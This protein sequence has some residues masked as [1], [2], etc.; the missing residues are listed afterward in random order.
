MSYQIDK[1]TGDIVMNGHE[2]GIADDPYSGIS[3]IRNMNLI[4]VPKEASVNFSTSKISYPTITNLSVLSSNA[5]ADTITFNASSTLEARMAIT[6]SATTIGGTSTGVIYYVGSV[7]GQTTCQLFTD[8]ALSALVDITGASGTATLSTL[9]PTKLLNWAYDNVNSYYY[10][11]D[12]SGYVWGTN[13]RTPSNFWTFTGNTTVTNA[14]G[15]GLVCYQASDG[16][17]GVGSVY[18][19]VFRNKRIDYAISSSPITWHYN[20][21]PASGAIDGSGGDSMITGAGT[22][23]SHQALVGQDNTVYYCDSN[24]LGSF[25]EKPLKAFNP[26]DTTTY[27]YAQKALQLPYFERAQCLAELGTNLLIGGIKSAIYPW[28]RISTSFKYPILLAENNIF[29]MVTVNTNTFVFIGNRG[30][31]Y[32]TNGTQGQ[33][34]KKV[35][36]H[37]SGTVEPYFT[38][39]GAC[40]I[41]NQLYFGCQATTNS[42]S[43]NANYGGVWAID[44]DT[45][46]IRLTNQLSYGTYAGLASIVFPIFG[47]NPAGTGLYIGWDN[48]SSVYGIDQTSST[49]YTGYQSYVDY[50]NIPIGTLL[51]PTT[52]LNIEWKLS[53]PMVSGEGVRVSYRLDFSQSYTVIWENTTAGVFSDYHPADFQNVQWVQ[54]RVETKSTGSSP[55]YTRLTE[56]RIR[57]K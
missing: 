10:A 53:K 21:L 37:L 20:W 23:N 16:S 8:Q 39:G 26:T 19:F 15:N 46:A 42:G 30:R 35:P 31:I 11:V 47:S 13:Y 45:K 5:G 34:Y 3:D 50:D 29:G 49:P 4:S 44:L 57:L 51:V 28:D 22:N 14:N 41:K 24:F 48:G 1:K 38:W 9:N 43:V 7:A 40:S 27:T 56:L 32:I 52:P 12:S 54:F 33:L 25:F 36:D 55:S 6:F 17:G 2:K 18:L